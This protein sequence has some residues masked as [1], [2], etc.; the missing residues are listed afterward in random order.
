MAAHRHAD[1]L[2]EC[3]QLRREVQDRSRV[4]VLAAGHRKTHAEKDHAEPGAFHPVGDI[5]KAVQAQAGLRD[6]R[7][8]DRLVFD[9][10]AKRCGNLEIL[11]GSNL[12]KNVGGLCARRLANINQHH[13]AVLAAARQK[14]AL[15]HDRVLGEVPRV[16]LRRVAPPVDDEVRPVLDLTQRARDLATQLGGYLSGAVSKRGVAVDHTSDQLGK[17]HSFTLGF[18]RDVAQPVHQGHVGVVEELGRGF[19]GLIECGRPAV[20]ERVWKQALRR[21]VLEPGFAEAAGVP[22]LENPDVVCMQ[23][24]VVAN[25]PAERACGVWY[26]VQ[27]HRSCFLPASPPPEPGGTT[28]VQPSSLPGKLPRMRRGM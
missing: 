28:N 1:E 15:L 3:V 12:Q 8:V 14:L 5:L 4:H 20:D 21:V 2:R 23:L 6:Q 22:G 16:A 13:R 24:D 26:D 19:D 17:R 10:G 25:T 7:P 27:S 18:T 11:P 9:Q